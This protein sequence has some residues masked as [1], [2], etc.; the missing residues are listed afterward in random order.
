MVRRIGWKHF[1]WRCRIM[2]KNTVNISIMGR[3]FCIACP[4][5]KKEEIELAAAYL[6]E[7]IQEVKTEGKVVDS[8]R[9]TIIA[10][11]KITHE[12]LILREGSGFDMD[13]FKRRIVTLKKKVDEVIANK[14][15]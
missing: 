6:N 12:L 2:N 5:D 15:N 3:E 9:V 4:A 10:A 8:D 7:K 13:E 1:Y 14:E 11:L